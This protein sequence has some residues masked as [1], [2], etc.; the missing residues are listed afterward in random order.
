MSE[1]IS[2]LTLKITLEGGQQVSQNVEVTKQQFDGLKQSI[3]E[4]GR[5]S[6]LQTFAQQMLAVDV[7]VEEA[8]ESVADFIKYNQLTETE[9]DQV[10]QRLRAEQQ[11][12]GLG[13]TAWK[14]HQ[15]AIS[16]LNQAYGLVIPQNQMLSKA[17]QQL[18]YDSNAARMMMQQVSY[19]LGDA[20]MFAVD[21]RMG[22]MGIS[23]NIPF[24]IQNYDQLKRSI[25]NTGISMLDVVK[26]SISGPMGMIMGANLLTVAMVALPKIL[27][28]FDK[29]TEEVAVTVDSL[30]KSVYTLSDGFENV[31]K[32]IDK[33]SFSELSEKYEKFVL[34]LRRTNE[35]LNEDTTLMQ[36]WRGITFQPLTNYLGYRLPWQE[37]TFWGM[38]LNNTKENK[39]TAEQQ[40]KGI[41]EIENIGNKIKTFIDSGYTVKSLLNVSPKDRD[42]I[43]KN[44][45][46]ILSA[47]PENISKKNIVLGNQLREGEYVDLGQY[48]RSD[49]MD[50]KDAIDSIN[51]NK[52]HATPK[53]HDDATAMAA[54]ASK[55]AEYNGKLKELDV[56]L[57]KTISEYDRQK[58]AAIEAHNAA[59]KAIDDE[60]AE[61]EKKLK[62]HSSDNLKIKNLN[63]E[64]EI[65][66]KQH[67]L[68]LYKLQLE[69]DKAMLQW[70]SDFNQQSMQL[71]NVYE[72]DIIQAKINYNKKLKLIEFDPEERKKID[73]QIVLLEQQKQNS[74]FDEQQNAAQLR[75]EAYFDEYSQQ[76]AQL[77]VWYKDMQFKYRG[78]NDELAS[79]EKQYANKRNAIYREEYQEK[80]K[81]T[82]VFVNATDVMFGTMWDN[83][84]IGSRQ[85]KNVWDAI[86]LSFKNSALKSLEQIIQ[87]NIFEEFVSML[88][89]TSSIKQANAGG[90]SSSGG[91]LWDYLGAAIP[92]FSLLKPSAAGAGI[93][94]GA[95][96]GIAKMIVDKIDMWQSNL[97]VTNDIRTMT[98]KQDQWTNYREKHIIK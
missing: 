19:T 26:N 34:G 71:N 46:D 6:F 29:K 43:Y 44:I 12:L 35:K 80:N 18:T 25:Q 40:Q 51:P 28:M 93:V 13:T 81:T 66:E 86:W 63:K 36:L 41:G 1:Q 5:S 72:S 39:K 8:A 11:Q 91:S 88:S 69:H 83:L 30:T 70:Q 77:D 16:M 45:K 17:T 92:I 47:W 10:T 87:S 84:V 58:N 60:I 31:Q 75:G 14:E 59:I 7:S 50:L 32:E 95:D 20:S 42:Y 54:Q 98:T 53:P 67:Q 64:R 96:A 82:M 68:N 3:D 37:D 33:M 74:L 76:L 52:K 4:L 21:L 78:H 48:K 24:I 56:L 15:G 94:S 57:N 65:E 27:D 38:D 73:K 49:L 22:F 89:G 90:N 55:Q 23:N 61:L 2:N 79:I 97:T 62:K 85:A 9:I